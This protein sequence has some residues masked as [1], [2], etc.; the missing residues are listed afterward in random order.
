MG[1]I[2]TGGS[3]NFVPKIVQSECREVGIP[4]ALGA[5][6]FAGLSPVTPTTR[7]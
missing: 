4:P 1:S 6:D 3:W 2:P 7:H 5:G